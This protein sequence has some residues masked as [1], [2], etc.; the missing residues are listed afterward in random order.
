MPRM[1]LDRDICPLSD[2]RANSATYIKQVHDTKRPL[3]ITQRGRSAA[4]LLDVGEYEA[5]L[6]RIE[7]SSRIS[8]V[9]KRSSNKGRGL[10]T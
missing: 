9:P 7:K 4:V 5:L 6:E 1:L 2:F 8:S 3:V 10:S